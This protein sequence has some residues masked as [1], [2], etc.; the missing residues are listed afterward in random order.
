MVGSHNEHT[1]RSVDSCA[2]ALSRSCGTSSSLILARPVLCCAVPV[3]LHVPLQARRYS[4]TCGRSPFD[5]NAAQHSTIKCPPSTVQC[6]LE[7]AHTSFGRCPH[8]AHYHLDTV[9]HPSPNYP[10]E[11]DAELQR[12]VVHSSHDAVGML[13]A[14]NMMET[15]HPAWQTTTPPAV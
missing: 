14:P 10:V 1:N 9:D 4:Q 5:V 13:V 7:I 11:E 6:P 15:N 8:I 12:E 2:G 3:A